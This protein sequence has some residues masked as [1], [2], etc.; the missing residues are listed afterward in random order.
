M[1]W[2][3]IGMVMFWY[4]CFLRFASKGYSKLEMKMGG[5]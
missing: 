5:D 4:V 2:I 3:E 1:G